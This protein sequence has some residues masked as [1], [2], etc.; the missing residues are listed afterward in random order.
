MANFNLNKV[1]LGGRMTADPVLKVTPSGVQVC[2]FSIAVNR[3]FAEEKGGEKAADFFNVTCW[4]QTAEFVSRY[5]RK[6]SSICVVGSIHTRSW[7]D[8]TGQKKFGVDIV[9]DEAY[10]V[11]AKNEMPQIRN[12]GVGEYAPHTGHVGE[13]APQVQQGYA[14]PA[15]QIGGYMPQAYVM[16]SPPMECVDDGELPF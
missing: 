6:A 11:D 8:Q 12:S 3:R 14:A 1:I 9:A 2:N 7:T 5:F 4:R 16:D 10:F 15:P 13:Y